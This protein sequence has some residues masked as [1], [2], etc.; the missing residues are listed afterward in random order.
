MNSR[1][2][3]IIATIGAVLAAGV[4]VAA[5]AHRRPESAADHG[6]PSEGSSAGRLPT[7]DLR[8][9][10]AVTG[11]SRPRSYDHPP[12]LEDQ[13]PPR[14]AHPADCSETALDGI[15]AV[16]LGLE[17]KAR[18]VGTST[19]P[20]SADA[21]PC[22][23]ESMVAERAILDDLSTRVSAC[24][25]KDEPLDSAWD[26]V[27]SALLA[28]ATCSDC[29]TSTAAR[30]TACSHARSELASLKAKKAKRANDAR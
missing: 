5:A 28:I 17:A 26:R 19:A 2:L 8:D 7:A 10:S 14:P 13:F 23:P 6:G 24:V 18:P 9:A 27:N 30:A 16:V 1:H 29:A 22:S 25:A 21:G 15:V 12:L 11:H 4:I 3:V 20:G